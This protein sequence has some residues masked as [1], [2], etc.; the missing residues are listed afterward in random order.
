MLHAEYRPFLIPVSDLRLLI[1][2]KII[3]TKINRE[4]PPHIKDV[5]LRSGEFFW[6]TC[7]HRITTVLGSCL[8]ICLW[9]PRKK[10]GGICH[11]LMPGRRSVKRT[12]LYPRYGDD[13]VWLILEMVEKYKTIAKEYEVK[14]F[15]G[16]SVL[17]PLNEQAVFSIAESNIG[18]A[19]ARLKEHGF[20]I[21]AADT[22][23]NSSRKIIFEMWSG[24]VWVKKIPGNLINR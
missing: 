10:I 11:Y 22:G 1:I 20:I 9:H 18:S 15:G 23:G 8:S 5:Y 12:P 14:I 24:D 4:I 13:A 21:K 19:K 2:M 6:G 7:N 3:S 16:S 17:F